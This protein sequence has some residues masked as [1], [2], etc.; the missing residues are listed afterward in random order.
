MSFR[1]TFFHLSR[2]K[3]VSEEQFLKNPKGFTA[4]L[5]GLLQYAIVDACNSITENSLVS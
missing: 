1:K 2:G 4:K 5:F 3:N